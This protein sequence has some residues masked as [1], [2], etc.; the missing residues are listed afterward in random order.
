MKRY[1]LKLDRP[2]HCEA[3]GVIENPTLVY[4]ASAD[5]PS[6]GQKVIAICHALT[7][8][9]DPE[10]WWPGMVGPGKT[11]DTEK[12]FIFCVAMLASPYGECG[13][14][15]IDPATGKPFYLDFPKVTVRDMVAAWEE[16]R[17]FLGIEKI[18]LL[19]GASIGGTQAIEWAVTYPDLIENLVAVATQ[20]RLS[21]WLVAGIEAQKMAIE[22][23]QTFLAR[24][25]L[26]GGKMGLRCA[27]AQAVISY[28]CPEGFEKKQSEDDVDV[29][30]S[31]K[32]ASYVRHQGDKLT[33]RFDAYSYYYLC[34]ALHSHNVGRG[35]GGVE[36]ALSR[37]KARTR[38]VAIDTDQIF[39]ASESVRW[40]KFIPGA[41]YVE[42][43]SLYG[44]DGFLL[45]SEQLSK[46]LEPFL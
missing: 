17:K 15:Q 9:S 14:A 26:E 42:M 38:V 24:E 43:K 45:E 27:R 7:A 37:I 3:G 25:S 12:Y 19:I 2:F 16:V 33:A 35:R 46:I 30:F 18:N 39:L 13:P 4:C 44:H 40:Y 23:D 1:S 21:P 8:N 29:L 41:D 36:A 10:E 31:D 32:A 11:F 6:E 28:R 20:P 22:A 34:Y 5:R